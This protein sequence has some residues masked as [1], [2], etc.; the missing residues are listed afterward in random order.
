MKLK[1]LQCMLINHDLL[2]ENVLLASDN[3]SLFL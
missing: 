1:I 3:L 2:L